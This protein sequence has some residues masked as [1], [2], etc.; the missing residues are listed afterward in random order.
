MKNEFEAHR[1]TFSLNQIKAKGTD[2]FPFGEF[3]GR[4]NR[5]IIDVPGEKRFFHMAVNDEGVIGGDGSLSQ[6]KGVKRLRAE[7]SSHKIFHFFYSICF[8]ADLTSR[9]ISAPAL[10]SGHGR[11]NS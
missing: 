8:H 7:E 9:H 2:I 6:Q 3:I 5:F 4:E 11:Q 10:Q 1:R